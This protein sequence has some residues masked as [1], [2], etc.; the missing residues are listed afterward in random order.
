[1]AR[2][3]PTVLLTDD[4]GSGLT[5]EIIQGSGIWTLTYQGKPV[6]LREM[7]FD[8]KGQRYSYPRC[9]Y[10]NP[11]HCY[12]LVDKMN[13]LFGTGDFDCEQYGQLD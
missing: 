1:M 13:E 2:P 3:A 5:T 10:N 8:E 6:Q 9:I 11:G 7:W 12:R 4:N